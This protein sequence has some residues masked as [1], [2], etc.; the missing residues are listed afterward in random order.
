MFTWTPD[1]RGTSVGKRAARSRHLSARPAS[2]PVI[3]QVRLQVVTA[4]RVRAALVSSSMVE[5]SLV[6]SPRPD[7][8]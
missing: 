2:L 3:F 5:S 7:G 1:A 4:K 6:S 8:S